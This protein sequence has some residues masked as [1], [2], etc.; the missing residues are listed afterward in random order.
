MLHYCN[1][2][3]LACLLLSARWSMADIIYY[4]YY[5]HVNWPVRYRLGQFVLTFGRGN[6]YRNGGRYLY[7]K[8]VKLVGKR[9]KCIEMAGSFNTHAYKSGSFYTLIETLV[10]K[11]GN[12]YTLVSITIS[13]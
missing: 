7:G 1:T 13:N 8:A 6:V 11:N 10:Y 2:N 12:F 9:I 5:S 3:M 4:V